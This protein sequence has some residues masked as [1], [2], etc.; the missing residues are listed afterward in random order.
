MRL[1]RREQGEGRAG[2]GDGAGLLEKTARAL[3]SCA[4]PFPSRAFIPRA[5]GMARTRSDAQLRK[6]RQGS[7]AQATSAERAHPRPCQAQPQSWR[8]LRQGAQGRPQTTRSRGGQLSQLPFPTLGAS[9]VA[10][11]R[12]RL[13][14]GPPLHHR[15]HHRADSPGAHGAAERRTSAKRPPPPRPVSWPAPAAEAALSHGAPPPVHPWR[16]SVRT[17]GGRRPRPA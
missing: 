12:P 13:S 10:R 3:G 9:R 14:R 11:Q 4:A 2:C 8:G 1:R 7:G 16:V 6:I 17:L 15:L 5:R